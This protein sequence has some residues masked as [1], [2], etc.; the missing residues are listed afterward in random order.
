MIRQAIRNPFAVT[1]GDDMFLELFETLKTK[2][3]QLHMAGR[4]MY[5]LM[6]KYN[7][8]VIEHIRQRGLIDPDYIEIDRNDE[9]RSK[10]I[11]IGA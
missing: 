3:H 5:R 4:T 9:H 10:G 11:G 8:I 6:K 1:F 7:I 2:I